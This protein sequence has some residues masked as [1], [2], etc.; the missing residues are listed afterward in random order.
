MKYYFVTYKAGAAFSGSK[1]PFITLADNDAGLLEHEK[2]HVRQWWAWAILI[3][4]LACFIPRDAE[5]GYTLPV[6]VAAFGLIFHNSLY[7]V[8]SSYRMWSEVRAYKIQ[9]KAGG[10]TLDRAA[11]VLSKYYKLGIS[12][13]E[14]KALLI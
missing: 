13:A 12:Q 1:G 6:M 10:I 11:E 4:A 14:A 9:L 7:T 3:G 2:F 8:S 5:L